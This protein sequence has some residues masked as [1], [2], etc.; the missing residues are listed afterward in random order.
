MA[1]AVNCATL[2]LAIACAVILRIILR[3]QNA[4]LARGEHVEGAI[5]GV[6]GQDVGKAFR[7]LL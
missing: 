4:K 2:A 1:F 3:R 6:P 5:Q 7:F